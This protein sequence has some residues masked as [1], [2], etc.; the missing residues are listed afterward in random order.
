MTG[1]GPRGRVGAPV[2]A[3]DEIQLDAVAGRIGQKQLG[4]FG[5]WGLSLA[6]RYAT[7]SQHRFDIGQI[8]AVEGDVI[9]CARDIRAS[10]FVRIGFPEM[11]NGPI[12]GI[13][14]VAEITKRRPRPD[15]QTDDI[16]IEIL[17]RIEQVALCVE[18]DVIQPGRGHAATV[19][20][21]AQARATSDIEPFVSVGIRSRIR[22]RRRALAVSSSDMA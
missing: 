20:R 9:E 13:E 15:V 18:I 12:A 2:S 17:E 1:S 3:V 4:L 21:I 14:P 6:V 8:R 19:A 16:A 11:D 5:A 10:H 22:S 7:R